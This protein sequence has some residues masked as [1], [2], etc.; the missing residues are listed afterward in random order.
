VLFRSV[1]VVA[2]ALRARRARGA[3]DPRA[4]GD[5]GARRGPLRLL[6]GIAVM[7]A[8]LALAGGYTYLR[9][10]VSA[11][12]PVFPQP[13]HAG[14]LQ[15]F[16]GREELSL[17]GRRGGE[18]SEIDV[19][20]FLAGA[21]NAFASF[22]PFTLLPAALLAPLVAA[23]RRRWRDAAVL[24]LAVV[25]F[26][27]FLYWTWDHRDIRYI[28]AGI[29]LAAVAYAWLSERLGSA[30]AWVR[31]ATFAVV[32]Y[33]YVRWLGTRG[34]WELSIAVLLVAAV[35]VGWRT[36]PRWRGRARLAAAPGLAVFAV[37][38]ALVLGCSVGRYQ[39]TKLA[40]SPAAMALE[41]LTGGRGATVGYVGLNQPY[42]FFGSR[43]QN[44]VRIVPRSFNLRAEHYRWRGVPEP[45]YRHRSFGRW[46]GVI[47][48]LGIEYVVV[49]R[50]PDEDPERAWMAQH[51]D[52]FRRVHVDGTTEIWKLLPATDAKAT[53]GP[54]RRRSAPPR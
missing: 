9:N 36:W 7:L 33:R 27:E 18:E 30:G 11:G 53:R 46:M 29:A 22:F 19:W 37:A 15:L 54:A 21:D 16:A 39:R 23:A 41:R 28:F 31:I 26:L 47:K 44:D 50:S 2:Y 38:A 8:T 51:W 10:W 4:A 52:R 20:S 49:V 25:F 6:P 32:L 12:N 14:G 13:V 43:L 40:D 3:V 34:A 45:P 42:L 17:G 1:F 35:V 5:E 48:V 24:A